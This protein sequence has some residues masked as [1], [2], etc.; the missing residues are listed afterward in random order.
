MLIRLY[1]RGR[2][3]LYRAGTVIFTVAVVVWALVYF[4]RPEALFDDY[5]A[6]R[7]VAQS[8]YSGPMLDEQLATIDHAE[9]AALLEQ[10]YLGRSGKLLEPAFRPLGW[11]WKITASVIASF[12]AREVVVA[13]L[14]TIYA[15]G[16]DVNETDVRLLDRL[17]RA[18][19]PDGTVVFT[20]GVAVGLM[21][22]FAFCLQ[23]MATVAIMRRETNGWKWPIFA[24]CYMTSLGYLGAFTAYQLL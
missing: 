8:T 13:V 17:R 7:T 9:S 20:L 15:V 11:D 6:Q 10:S 1:D 4:P 16:D 22:F 21:I 2:I 14:G 18:R 3:F 5:S 19:H 12:P 23:C 24:W